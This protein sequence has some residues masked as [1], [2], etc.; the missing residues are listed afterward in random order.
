VLI[1][2]ERQAEWMLDADRV[3]VISVQREGVGVRLAVKTR[4]GGIPA[5]TEPMEVTRWDP[6]HRLYIR[7]GGLVAGE[8]RWTLEPVVGGTSFVWIEDIRLA[9][10]VVGEP[11]AALYGPV[12]RM[13]MGRAMDGLRRYV[14]ATGPRRLSP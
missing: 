13:L 4:I 9:V 1:D 7:H 6:P 3:E 14:I 11:A 10:P 12:M 5:F 8:G 2:W